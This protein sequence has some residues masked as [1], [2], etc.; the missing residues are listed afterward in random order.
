M[1]RPCKRRRICAEPDCRTFGPR[2]D[3]ETE[4]VVMTLDEFEKMPVVFIHYFREKWLT[5]ITR[6]FE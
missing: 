6:D 1:P 2:D 5:N 3:R 4:A